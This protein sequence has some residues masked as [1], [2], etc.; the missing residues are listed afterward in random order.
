MKWW[1]NSVIQCEVFS[2]EPKLEI[3][4]YLNFKR[5]RSRK[6][7]PAGLNLRSDTWNLCCFA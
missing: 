3:Q 1:D 6:M 7:L 5:I 4:K 2:L